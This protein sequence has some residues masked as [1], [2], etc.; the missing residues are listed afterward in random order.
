MVLE[1]Y[2]DFKSEKSLNKTAKLKILKLTKNLRRRMVEHVAQTSY[3]NISHIISTIWCLKFEK[4]VNDVREIREFK[5]EKSL[6]KTAKLKI[7]KLTKNSGRRMV[8]H[9]AQTSYV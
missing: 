2:K 3:V 4:S 8:E 9:A 7:L 5:F 1:N 6:N